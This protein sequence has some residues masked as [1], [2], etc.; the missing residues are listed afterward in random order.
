MKITS[1]RL[2]VVVFPF[3]AVMIMSMS[4]GTAYAHKM[5]V[6]GD[7]KVEIGWDQEPPI[8]GIKN[9]LTF[10]VTPATEMD[11][12]MAEAMDM[13][14]GEEGN[15]GQN[16]TMASD[17]NMGQNET[18]TSDQNMGHEDDHD[19]GGGISGLEDTVKITI[20][21]GD[22]TTT[23]NLA[24]T[25]LEGIY[26]GEFVA[27]SSGY[28]VAHISGMIKDTKIDLDMHPD[29]VEPLSVLP[30]LKQ[31]SLGINPGEVQCKEGLKLFKRLNADSSICASDALGERL[32]GFGVVDYF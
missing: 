15:M 20:T 32:M 6:V 23:L 17:Q 28:P 4:L 18:M 25:D 29:Q 27:E 12:Q 5:D 2:T 8:Q 9:A 1:K 16:E 7:Y 24:P 31:I 22:Q 14:M 10:V 19:L 21:L 13:V 3:L 30:P 11:R 26:L